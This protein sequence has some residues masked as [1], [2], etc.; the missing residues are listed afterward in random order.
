MRFADGDYYTKT[1][2]T[3]SSATLA[4]PVVITGAGRNSVSVSKVL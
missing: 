3:N 2:T 4:V 1:I